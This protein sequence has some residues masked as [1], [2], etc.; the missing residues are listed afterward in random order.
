MGRYV[1]AVLLVALVT[2]FYANRRNLLER[3]LEHGA[4][5]DQIGAEQQQ[6]AE[7]QKEI[8]ST[9]RRVENLDSDP[10]EI[11]AA[12]RRS[13]DLVREGETIYR[14]ETGPGGAPQ[15]AGSGS[16]PVAP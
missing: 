5:E 14:I 2:V 11:E 8:D 9:R 6:C 1:V 4:R 10:L 7:L 12:I 3:Y 15:S 13:K 16:D